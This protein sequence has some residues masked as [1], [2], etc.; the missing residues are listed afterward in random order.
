MSQQQPQ[1]QFSIQDVVSALEYLREE[2]FSQENINRVKD[3]IDNVGDLSDQAVA[4]FQ[5]VRG[6]IQ[7]RRDAEG[8]TRSIDLSRALHEHELEDLFSE[9]ERTV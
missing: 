6:Y 2:V 3:I 9:F 4:M 1:Q 8:N 7:A 5:L